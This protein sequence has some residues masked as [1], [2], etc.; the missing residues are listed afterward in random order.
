MTQRLSL[1]L[2]LDGS[3]KVIPVSE[4]EKFSSFLIGRTAEADL[5]LNDAAVS[6]RHCWIFHRTQG[7]AIEDLGSQTLGYFFGGFASS[8][9]TKMTIRKDYILWST[10]DTMMGDEHLRVLGIMKNFF[11]LEMPRSLEARR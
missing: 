1:I 2:V 7:I 9:I 5:F 6:R 3:K 11:I 8:I 4:G 10:Y